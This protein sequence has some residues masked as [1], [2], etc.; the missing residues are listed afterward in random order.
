MADLSAFEMVEAY[1]VGSRS[2]YNERK[3]LEQLEEAEDEEFGEHIAKSHTLEE[4]RENTDVE[5]E[6]QVRAAMKG[7][8]DRLAHWAQPGRPTQYALA[9]HVEGLEGFEPGVDF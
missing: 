8:E 5:N 7:N 6:E 4:I 9:E 3:L 2:R 1:L